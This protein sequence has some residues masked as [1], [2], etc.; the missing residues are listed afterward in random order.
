M[1]NV[2][3][4]LNM[5]CSIH[6]IIGMIPWF[7]SET[8]LSRIPCVHIYWRGDRQNNILGVFNTKIDFSSLENISYLLQL[9]NIRRAL[10]FG[11]K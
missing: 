7:H 3:S 8:S 10:I 1:E 2:I 6:K 11:I 9:K 4:K 5:C